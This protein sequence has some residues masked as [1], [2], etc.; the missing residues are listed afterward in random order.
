MTRVF[1]ILLLIVFSLFCL[2]LLQ[3]ASQARRDDAFKQTIQPF[4]ATYCAGCHNAEQKSGGLNLEVFQSAADVA[5]HREIW[6]DVA[7]RLRSG[8][9][10]PKGMPR[11][12]KMTVERVAHWIELECARADRT[13]RPDP[14]RVTARRLNRAEYNNTIRDLLG[15]DIEPAN[16]FPQ[17]D[18]AHGFDNIADALSLSPTLLEKYMATAEKIARLAVFGPD[19]APQTFRIEPTRPRRLETNPVK[20]EQPPF[21]S[22]QDYD[23]TGVSHP[24]AYHLTHRFPATGEYQF[25]VR[26]DGAKPPGSDPQTLDLYINGRVVQSFEVPNKLT[27][28]NER[29]PVF[30]EIRLPVTAGK[31]ELIAAFPRLFEGLPPAFNG[32]HPTTRPQP[33]PPDPARFFQPLPAN[34]TPEQIKA[35]EAQIERFRSRKPTFEGMAIAE[36]EING[37]FTPVRGPSAA[38]LKKLY[39]CGHPQGNHQAGCERRIVAS[40]AHRAFRRPLETAELEG[41]VAI[42]TSAQQRGRTFAQGLALALQAILVSPDF[43]FRVERD[44][45][46]DRRA[47][48]VNAPRQL[49]AHELASRLSYFLWSSMPDDE[50]LALADSGALRR[51]AVRMAQVRRML[52]D[53]KSRALVENFAGQWL[54]IRRLESAQPDRDRFPDFDDYLRA[55]MLK[56]TE[57]FFR[58]I[59]AEDR[60]ITDFIDAKYTFLN[61]RLARHYGIVGVTGNE[62]RRVDLGTAPRRGILTQASV[63]TVSSYGNRTSPVLRG[64]YILE[65]LLNTPPPPPP[66]NVPMLDETVVGAKISMRQ[67]LEQHR[68][69][70]VCASCHAR[71]DPLGF[72][73][74]NFDAVG[75]WRARDGKFPID[76]SGLLPDGKSFKNAED[77]IGILSTQR[78]AFAEALT[79]KLLTY[80]LGRGV[81]R[82]DRAVVRQIAARVAARE[83]RFSSLVQEI[84]GSLPFQRRTPES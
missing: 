32:P 4:V 48:G 25:R 82:R 68:Q 75:A 46:P 50:L 7:N 81:E 77:L 45:V 9:M 44:H 23:V 33:P 56:E 38:A 53:L 61:E 39:V 43:L 84:T 55:S 16:D 5:K 15:L 60:G 29:L 41:L 40:L 21:Y 22:M 24:G 47:Q 34:P 62:F 63:L 6:E 2:A 59:I 79:E 26:A 20:L 35:R 80:A 8:Q 19:D 11:P 37:P 14:G 71:M 1:K 3:P 54:E 65:N 30:M 66:P 64:K 28:T 18:S 49:T 78:D 27:A 57:L 10:P 17:D 69:N 83:Y 76:P 67:Q 31:H 73:L 13:A 74:E 58:N 42:M 70:A 36:L 72:S 52:K 51:P 12:D